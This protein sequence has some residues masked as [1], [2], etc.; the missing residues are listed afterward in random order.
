MFDHSYFESLETTIYE[1]A[2][3]RTRNSTH[4]ILNKSNSFVDFITVYTNGTHN[5]IRMTVHILCT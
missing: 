2:I 5:N 1:K 4:S 3:K